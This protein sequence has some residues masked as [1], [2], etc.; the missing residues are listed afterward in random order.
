MKVCQ[1]VIGWHT[2]A[3]LHELSTGYDLDAGGYSFEVPPFNWFRREP[4]VYF[5]G[6]FEYIFGSLRDL[7]VDEDVDFMLFAPNTGHFQRYGFPATVHEDRYEYQI[8]FEGQLNEPDHE[9]AWCDGTGEYQ[10]DHGRT[11]KS[12]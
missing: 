5:D 2:K 9:C 3:A 10:S 7:G 6:D 4:V 11:L 8:V 1:R 12:L